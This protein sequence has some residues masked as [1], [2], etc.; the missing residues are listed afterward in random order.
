MLS[1]KYV[2]YF[3][4]STQT[5]TTNNITFFAMMV[6]YSVLARYQLLSFGGKFISRKL[7]RAFDLCVMESDWKRCN[8]FFCSC[9]YCFI[10]VLI[11][12]GESRP[13]KHRRTPCMSKWWLCVNAR[14]FSGGF[15]SNN[16]D[17]KSI[18]L[19]IKIDHQHSFPVIRMANRQRQQTY[20]NHHIQQNRQLMWKPFKSQFLKT[21][22]IALFQPQ[23]K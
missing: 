10:C 2:R 18:Q 20:N 11:S 1:N 14:I 4:H 16:Q 8:V 19:S 13:Q 9:Y 15:Q 7:E 6:T 3:G 12:R 17:N 22:C 23:T 5:P 21:N